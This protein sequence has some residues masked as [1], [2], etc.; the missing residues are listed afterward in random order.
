[1]NTNLGE[2]LGKRRVI[3]KLALRRLEE[4]SGVS[5]SYISRI[6]KGE[7]YPSASALRQLAEPLGF[8]EIE[9]FKIAG[10]LS[11]D[12][13]DDRL[14]RFKA[15]VL[16]EIAYSLASLHARVNIL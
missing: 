7:R 9:L 1:M 12:E 10:F 15:E 8:G 13:G 2:I 14:E 16:K 3:K 11:K 4:M 5:K 6:E